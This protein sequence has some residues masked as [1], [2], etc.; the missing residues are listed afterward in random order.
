MRDQSAD[1][2]TIVSARSLLFVPATHPGRFAKAVASGAD[3]VIIDLEDAVPGDGKAEAR[4][5]AAAFLSQEGRAVVRIN[6]HG[7]EHQEKDI[8]AIS[9]LPGLSGVMIP[10]SE[11]ADDVDAVGR[12]LEV[13][14]IPLI[15]S[16]RGVQNA[17][18]IADAEHTTRIALGDQDLMADLGSGAEELI[19]FARHALT[20]A[21]A[22]AALP[23]SIDGISLAV[24]D[25][26]RVRDSAERGRALGFRG[27]LCIHPN[28]VP[29]VNAAFAPSPEEIE[30]A[31]RVHDA[32]GQAVAVMDDGTFVDAPVFKRAQAILDRMSDSEQKVGTDSERQ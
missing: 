22:A 31:R 26:D 18:E 27:K 14:T 4:D 5:N 15:E 9:G 30:W 10:K 1:T 6:S 17:T 24:G 21:A 7:S 25:R 2:R 28:Q 29:V 16:A 23:G 11:S 32:S 3:V 20:Y 13:P 19:T 8:A 12:A